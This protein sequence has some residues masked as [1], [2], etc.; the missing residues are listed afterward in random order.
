M[1][2]IFGEP[3]LRKDGTPGKII[4]LPPLDSLQASPLTRPDWVQ[5]A[6]YDAKGTWLL[7][8]EL[9]ARLSRMEWL[10]TRSLFDFYTEYWRPFGELLTDMERA[11]VMVDVRSKLPLAQTRA[12]ADR[13]AA[14]LTFRKWAARYTEAAWYMNVGSGTQVQTLLFGGATRRNSAEVLPLRRTFKL[15]RA[16]FEELHVA[17]LRATGHAH[18]AEAGAAA[19]EAAAR[20]AAGRLRPAPPLSR[21]TPRGAIGFGGSWP[22]PRSGSRPAAVRGA[23]STARMS[24][25]SGLC[26]TVCRRRRSSKA[27]SRAAS[28]AARARPTTPRRRGAATRRERVLGRT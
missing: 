2:E 13:D 21:R 25:W 27:S 24:S 16:A 28:S 10:R 5:Y 23:I 19:R 26:G 7:Y 14:E 17:R 3:K 9:E 18:G 15:E 4:E 8:R 12:Q 22:R 20:E 6:V 1:K 11:G